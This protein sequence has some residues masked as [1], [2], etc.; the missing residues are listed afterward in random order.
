MRGEQPHRQHIIRNEPCHPTQENTAMSFV[1]PT[2]KHFNNE[3]SLADLLD[4]VTE[5]TKGVAVNG[6]GDSAAANATGST[7][8]AVDELAKGS[9]ARLPVD[10]AV[11]DTNA[12]LDRIIAAHADSLKNVILKEPRKRKQG[13]QKRPLNPNLRLGE[14]RKL[15]YGRYDSYD[16]DHQELRVLLHCV[17]KAHRFLRRVPAVLAEIRDWAPHMP[18]DRAE[19]L[20]REIAL[21]P[22]VWGSEKMAQELRVTIAE[23]DHYDLRTIGAV[24]MTK[25]ERVTRQNQR[26]REAGFK[27]RRDRK[28]P[29]LSALKPWQFEGISRRT[30]ETSGRTVNGLALALLSM[31]KMNCANP[32]PHIPAPLLWGADFAQCGTRAP[33]PGKNRRPRDRPGRPPTPAGAG[34]IRSWEYLTSPHTNT[35]Q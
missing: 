30:W 6:G 25:E 26:R 31:A 8:K 3:A 16:A 14:V 15:L 27:R 12:D 17:A 34:R 11:H 32:A 10:A 35:F 2:G 28:N 1:P 29:K 20:A 24:D 13:H 4:T 22:I 5:T 33:L 9:G 21:N 7:A 19:K 18:K 23:R